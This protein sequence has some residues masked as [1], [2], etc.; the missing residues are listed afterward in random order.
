MISSVN[1]G[2][3]HIFRADDS[4]VVT[5]DKPIACSKGDTYMDVVDDILR[6]NQWYDPET[7]GLLIKFPSSREGA[8]P[9]DADPESSGRTSRRDRTAQ[10]FH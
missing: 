2:W 6:L 9:S 7:E 3:I 4:G 10:R 5:A 1:S 8:Q